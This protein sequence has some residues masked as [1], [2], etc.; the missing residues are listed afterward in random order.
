MSKILI[1]LR[2]IIHNIVEE[3]ICVDIVYKLLRQ[4][5]ILKFHVNNSFNITGKQIIKI[6]KTVNICHLKFIKGK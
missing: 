3:N 6:P 5:K 2:M 4:K 1:H